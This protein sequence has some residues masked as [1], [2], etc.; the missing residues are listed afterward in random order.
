V[1]RL[2]LPRDPRVR[3]ESEARAAAPRE[4]CGLVEGTDVGGTFVVTAIHPT[5]NVAAAADAFEI[6]PAG[7]IALLRALRGTGRGI[8]GCYH[9]HPG[10]RPEPSARDREAAV[11][12][13]FV[14]L[15]AAW[16]GP[17][18]AAIAAFLF[19]GNGFSPL[20]ILH[21]ASLDPVRRPRL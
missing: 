19:G 5:A 15:I 10:G 9:S 21:T 14:W 6:D 11:E 12:A 2:I 3:I 16:S 1:N 7:H 20:P 13:G 8:I 18:R 4:C 17:D